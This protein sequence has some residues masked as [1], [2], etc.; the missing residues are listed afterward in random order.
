[1][2]ETE[3][4]YRTQSADGHAQVVDESGKVVL[5]CGK[6]NLASAEQ[7]AV[8]LNQAFQRGFKAGFRAARGGA[9]SK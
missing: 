8:L 7:Y 9:S 5:D 3:P 2:D 6:V 4:P 1:M